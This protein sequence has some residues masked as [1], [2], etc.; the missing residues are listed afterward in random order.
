ML[1][2]SAYPSGDQPATMSEEMGQALQPEL[3][4]T[5]SDKSENRS[6]RI[7]RWT[8]RLLDLS[9]RN[10][11]LNLRNTQLVIPLVCP[12]ISQLEDMLSNNQAITIGPIPETGEK[13]A[14]EPI[15]RDSQLKADLKEQLDKELKQKRLC[16]TLTQNEISRR[17]TA[18]SRQGKTDLEEGG[19]NTIFIGIGFLEWKLTPQDEKTYLAPI[20]LLPIR[21]I[22]K[23]IVEGF[24]IQRLD[25]DTIINE[26]L[27]ELMRSQFHLSVSGLSP[28]PADQDGVHVA[29]VMQR[30]RESIQGMAGWAVHEEAAIGHFSFAK[31]IMW[32]DMTAR[33]E[34]LSQHPLVN[35]LMGGGGVFEDG[36]EVFPPEEVSRHLDLDK[37]TCPMSADSSQLAA[38]LYSTLGKSFVLH[39][40][41]GTGKSQTITNIIA[42]NLAMG[43]RV[44]FVS[45]KKAA[46][47]VVHKRLSL[48]GLRPFCLELHS[49]KSG[50]NE[51]LAQFSEAL[52]VPDTAR[53]DQWERITADLERLR[54]ELTSY[55]TALHR[56]YPNAISA[57]DC[58]SQLIQAQPLP[59]SLLKLPCLTQTRAEVDKLAQLVS[60]LAHALEMLTSKTSLSLNWL[61]LADWSP[62]YEKELLATAKPL[63]TATES[64][65][66]IYTEY[67]SSLQLPSFPSGC[68]EAPSRGYSIPVIDATVR[69]A[70]ALQSSPDIP[71]PLISQEIAENA[72]FLRQFKQVAQQ[73]QKL[74]LALKSY[75]LEMA[76]TLNLDGIQSRIQQNRQ[77]FFLFRVFKNKALLNELSGLKKLG[78]TKLTIDELAKLLPQL[79]Q[80]NDTANAF[81]KMLDQGKAMLGKLWQED[82]TDWTG[83]ESIL[84]ATEG[85]IALLREIAGDDATQLENCLTFLRPLLAKA[86]QSFASSGPYKTGELIE[87][88]NR[89]KTALKDFSTYAEPLL[90]ETHITAL[91]DKIDT[92]LAG[93][94]S[95]RNILRYQQLL[96]EANASGLEGFARALEK[97]DLPAQEAPDA[98]KTAYAKEM[99]DQILTADATLAHF[100]GLAHQQRID[101]FRKLDNDYIQLSRKLVFA[102]LAATLPR[103]R[104]GPC[105]DGTQLGI[106]KRECEKKS[107]HKPVRQLLS[108]I[109]KLAA[110]LKPC[111]LMSP[112]SVAQYLP[113]DSAPFDLIV[114]DEASQIPVWDAIGVIARGKQLIV[115]GDPKQMPPT[116]FFLKDDPRN[117]D[118]ES[119]KIE[120]L[121]SILDECLAAGLYSSYLNWH[122][123]SRHE[124]LIAFSNHYYYEDRLFT[125]PSSSIANHLG[126]R[127]HLVPNAVYDKSNTRTN[128]VEAEAL[129]AYIFEQLENATSRRRSFGVVTF[130][131]AQK[132]LIED[133]LEQ[134]RSKHPNLEECFSDQN[135][136]PPFVKNLENV[137]GDERDV[138][139]F[140]IG[141]APDSAGRFSMNFGPLNRVGG[142][143]R[144]NVAI[145]RAKEQVVVFSSIHAYQ[146]ELS[147]TAA[148]GAAHLK[149]FL[150]YAEKGFAIQTSRTAADSKEGLAKSIAAFLQKQGYT[151]E[152]G[153]GC[154]GHR[155]DVAVLHPDKQGT[156]LLGIEC[157]GPAYASQKTTRDRDHIRHSVL[158]SLG[159]HLHQIWSVDWLL[160]RKLAEE[161][162]LAALEEA[163]TEPPQKAK[164]PPP[165]PSAPSIP[166]EDSQKRETP[167]PA[168]PT[169]QTF[170]KAAALTCNRPQEEFFQLNTRLLIRQQMHT[171]IQQEAPISEHLL[172]KRILKAWGFAQTGKNI[173][174]VLQDSLP[175]DLPTTRL[176]EEKVFWKAD[177]NPAEYREYRAN[178]AD[179]SNRRAID[180][181]PPEE[182]ANAMREIIADFST[183]ETDALYRETLRRFGLSNLTPKSRKYLAAAFET[184]SL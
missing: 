57:Y 169:P 2:E 6:G 78:G 157:D 47:D 87:A 145:T 3:D 184:L 15:L 136:E 143:R 79:A 82:A 19:V 171:I 144:L 69:L 108:E 61:A 115:V 14:N 33:A 11:L 62:A 147:R 131:E 121:E 138:I 167:R 13:K 94:D 50:K 112:L 54:K 71:E 88:W 90:S 77:A 148:V 80:W 180:D 34:L 122:Y 174:A 7:A 159:W 39:G 31:F 128:R 49:N 104:S 37:L 12:D 149:N 183:I 9:L 16:S 36:I 113:P 10:R 164:Q 120:D 67:A 42:Q 51:V 56:Q 17:M 45:E 110:T 96:H 28:L 35:H 181:I 153:I 5:P 101:Q 126:V 70:Q 44:L 58:F 135:E 24:K 139:L 117:D 81:E 165:A 106:L 130:N 1:Q 134:E 93:N 22:R 177:Q 154:S 150:D 100:N 41:P 48:V 27:L 86:T 91:A 68:Q 64:L 38:V 97:G 107:R 151:V 85:I 123:R 46:L 129:V 132:N 60:D 160:D 152:L 99:L 182:L 119:D 105:P 103:F 74:K 133:L 158:T 63:Q 173:Q 127:F 89:Q 179:E 163:K 140:S 83:V 95:L 155:I 111:F 40:P 53:P 161:A 168:P 116:N 8:Q 92:L 137:Q 84:S 43:R 29:Q 98:F 52:N 75:N 142:E 125:F 25:E 55:V 30:L 146:I 175:N 109:P 114:F 59:D 4:V 176:A 32:T 65:R 118:E 20:L 166:P 66:A 21:L 73:R 102:K 76:R 18:L 172:K 156:Y 141:Y 162:L 23:S 72:A 178:A 170:Y 124:S 26:T